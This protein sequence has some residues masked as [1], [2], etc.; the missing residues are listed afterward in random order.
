MPTTVWMAGCPENVMPSEQSLTREP[1]GGKFRAAAVSVREGWGAG[2]DWKR[3]QGP[4]EMGV[5]FVLKGAGVFS[6]TQ[7]MCM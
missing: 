6:K 4:E 3:C 7:E 1:R 5:F 2:M